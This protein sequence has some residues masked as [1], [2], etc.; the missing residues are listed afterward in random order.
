M[1]A[2][3]IETIDSKEIRTTKFGMAGKAAQGQTSDAKQAA[4]GAY[5]S[6]T[7]ALA[8]AGEMQ[9]LVELVIEIRA[10]LV[11]NGMMKGSS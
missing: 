6:G 1:P 5:A 2:E 8:S 10:A 7:A 3:T 9:K 11:A 4:L